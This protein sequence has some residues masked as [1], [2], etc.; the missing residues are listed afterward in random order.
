VGPKRLGQRRGALLAS[1]MLSPVTGVWKRGKGRR[2]APDG[3]QIGRSVE[4]SA[5]AGAWR[6]GGDPRTRGRNFREQFSRA[7]PA[8]KQ[9]QT[10]DMLFLLFPLAQK[11]RTRK[12]RW[13]R[14]HNKFGKENERKKRKKKKR[15]EKRIEKKGKR[16][17]PKTAVPG[18]A[19]ERPPVRDVMRR[20]ESGAAAPGVSPSSILMRNCLR[21]LL[22]ATLNV[23]RYLPHGQGPK[24]DGPAQK[25]PRPAFWALAFARRCWSTKGMQAGKERL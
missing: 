11:T 13:C 23:E 10:I 9:G 14:A 18:P 22:A 15:R 20:K 12:R 21:A 6:P 16:G 17:R 24:R 19:G 25:Q 4:P 5:A 2:G 7:T 8:G 1:S 3:G